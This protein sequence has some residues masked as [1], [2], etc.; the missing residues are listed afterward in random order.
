MM[1]QMLLTTAS[2]DWGVTSRCPFSLF[3]PPRAIKGGLQ[4][5]LFSL[6]QT[7]MKTIFVHDVA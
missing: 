4:H 7:A 3:R 2:T 5:P 6:P 1:S